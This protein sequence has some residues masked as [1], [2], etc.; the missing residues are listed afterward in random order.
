MRGTRK[1]AEMAKALATDPGESPGVC[2]ACALPVFL[3][4]AAHGAAR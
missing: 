2:R 1:L 4:P 3:S